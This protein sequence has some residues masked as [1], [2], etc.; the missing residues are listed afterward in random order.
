MTSSRPGETELP[1]QMREKA[2]P[3]PAITAGDPG[4]REV[5]YREK[6]ATEGGIEEKV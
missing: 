3:P 6:R 2:E 1:L 4:R 5:L